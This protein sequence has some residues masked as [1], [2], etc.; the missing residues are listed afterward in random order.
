MLLISLPHNLFDMLLNANFH[1]IHVQL[2]KFF[3]VIFKHALIQGSKKSG[4]F[5]LNM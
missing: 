2:S 4:E 5:I 3:V 1:L